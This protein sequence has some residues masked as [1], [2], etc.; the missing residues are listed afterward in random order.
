MQDLPK[1]TF[2]ITPLKDYFSV[3]EKQIRPDYH[4]YDSF[5]RNYPELIGSLKSSKNSSQTIWDFFQ[6]K[7]KEK[8]NDL[9]LAKG[10]YNRAWEEISE[11]FLSLISEKIETS[12]DPEFSE[13][14]ARITLNPICPRYLK[15][16]TFDLFWKMSAEQAKV[17]ILHELSH[18]L[19][20]KKIKEIFPRVNEQEFE[21]PHLIWKLSEIVPGTLFSEKVLELNLPKERLY[22]PFLDKITLKGELMLEKIKDLYNKSKDFE[23]FVKSSLEYLKENEEELNNQFK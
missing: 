14:T 6:E 3:L 12:W 18:F 2:E 10:R 15:Y 4:F 20:F 13:F 9:A 8:S 7:E 21:F 23:E 1:V 22:Y 5:Q 19:F 11:T 17:V 16:S